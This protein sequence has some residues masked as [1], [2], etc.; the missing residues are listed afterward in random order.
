METR[1]LRGTVTG[2]VFLRGTCGGEKE[3]CGKRAKKNKEA[4]EGLWRGSYTALCVL[5]GLPST[6]YP[7]TTFYMGNR[8]SR[9]QE[10][11]QGRSLACTFLPSPS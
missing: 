2:P 7:H 9:E 1:W 6:H 10:D 5:P 3:K 11:S 4:K 8:T